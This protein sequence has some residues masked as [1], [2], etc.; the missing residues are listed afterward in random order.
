LATLQP[1]PLAR[2]RSAKKSAMK[3]LKLEI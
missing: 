1:R 3:D 2:A